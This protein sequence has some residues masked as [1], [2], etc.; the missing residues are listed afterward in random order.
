MFLNLPINYHLFIVQSGSMEPG[1]KTGSLVLVSKKNSYQSGE[2][3]TYRNKT[4]K[5]DLNKNLTTTHRIVDIVNFEG[6]SSYRTKGDANLTPEEN[7][8]T[9][10]EIVGKV[11]WILPFIGYIISFAK[12]RNGLIFL[13]IIPA[14]IIIYNEVI[15]IID[16]LKKLTR[17]KDK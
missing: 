15:S 3:I 14:T 4:G 6:E 8:V 5:G 11:V 16:E 10:E 13:I 1:I 7:L 12:T 9:N 2:I 17:K